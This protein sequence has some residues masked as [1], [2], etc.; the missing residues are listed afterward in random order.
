MTSDVILGLLLIVGSTAVYLLP[1]WVALLRKKRNT[2]PIFIVNLLCG[3][4]G[5]GWLVALVWSLMTDTQPT[6]VVV[7]TTNVNR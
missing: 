7:T 2:L 4:T 5:V 6:N 1:T 3:W